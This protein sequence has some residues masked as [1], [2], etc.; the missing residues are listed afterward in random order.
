MVGA[1]RA[2]AVPRRG[3]GHF[4]PRDV[5][6]RTVCNLGAVFR[7]AM[8]QRAPWVSEAGGQGADWLDR[9]AVSPTCEP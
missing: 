2:V 8:G 6:S 7:G 1:A 4:H 3:V 5:S 9:C